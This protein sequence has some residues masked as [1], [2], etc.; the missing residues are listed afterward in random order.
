MQQPL[1]RP[2]C[3]VDCCVWCLKA[4]LK[5]RP[6]RHGAVMPAKIARAARGQLFERFV[7]EVPWILVCTDMRE[8]VRR[9]SLVARAESCLRLHPLAAAWSA[10]S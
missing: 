2:E 9:G 3:A 1:Q 4:R 8:T 6:V 5:A 10:D 7:F